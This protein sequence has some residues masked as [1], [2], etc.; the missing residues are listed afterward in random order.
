MDYQ[1]RP[2]ANEKRARA[3][4]ASALLVTNL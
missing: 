4:P 3:S 2:Q 1:H